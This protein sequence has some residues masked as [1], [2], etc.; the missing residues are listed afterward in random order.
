MPSWM[1]PISIALV[2]TAGVA[3]RLDMRDRPGWLLGYFAFFLA[4][5][6]ALERWAL[7]PGTLGPEVAWVCL[8]LAVALLGVNLLWHRYERVHAT[9]DD[10]PAS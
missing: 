5:E 4:L 8:G 2:L 10:P 6:S 9:D 3:L 7:P 1:V